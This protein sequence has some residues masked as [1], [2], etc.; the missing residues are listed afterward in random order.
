[1]AHIDLDKARKLAGKASARRADD[2][3]DALRDL[4]EDCRAAGA[5]STRA[6]AK[7]LNDRGIRSANGGVARVERLKS[8]GAAGSLRS[9]A[10]RESLNCGW[11]WSM[12]DGS[13]AGAPGRRGS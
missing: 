1:V 2:R 3:A 9:A 6:L 4:V 13:P 8:A 7:A 10:R 5:T 11:Q 12:V